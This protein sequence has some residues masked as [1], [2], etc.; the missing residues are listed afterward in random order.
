MVPRIL[1]LV[2]VPKET[3]IWTQTMEEH[4]ILRRCAYW[5][6]LRGQAPKDH[7][8]NITVRFPRL[9]LFDAPTLANLMSRIGSGGFP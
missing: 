7:D 2:T 9:Q 5:M 3:E 6:S 1:V 8:S 4:L